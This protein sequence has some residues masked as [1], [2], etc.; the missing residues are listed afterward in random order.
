MGDLVDGDGALHLLA[1]LSPAFPIG[2]FAY[3]HGVETAVDNGDVHD[4]AS[5]TAWLSDLIEVGSARN[6][7]ILAAEAWRG[8][9]LNDA[10]HLAEI[11]DLAFALCPSRERRL[12]TGGMGTA[13]A[14]TIL[15]A[16]PDAVCSTLP[17]GEIAYPVA[18]G[19][20][21]AAQGLRLHRC[22]E[23]YALAFVQTI[24]SAAVRLGP[25]GQ[26]DG[27]RTAA[28]LLPVVRRLATAAEMSSLDDLG[29][30]VLRSDL[31]AMKHET[32]YSRLFRS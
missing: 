29:G 28:A 31:A 4:L 5:L 2:A 19:A 1:W 21:C 18:F 11:N 26:T 22:L 13:F 17:A 6:D 7:A 24:V 3:S 20:T 15:N 27:Q 23:A 8:A 16:W 32:L 25:I 14:S 10:R 9:Q 30:C 12:E